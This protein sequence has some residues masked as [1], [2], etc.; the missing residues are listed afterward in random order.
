MVL[1]PT[2]SSCAFEGW[3]EE[4]E[5]NIRTTMEQYISTNAKN[6]NRCV[7]NPIADTAEFLD[8]LTDDRDRSFVE[9]SSE[10]PRIEWKHSTVDY[11]PHKRTP[12]LRISQR[13]NRKKWSRRARRGEARRFVRNPD[14]CLYID[15]LHPAQSAQSAKSPSP[16]ISQDGQPKR[17]PAMTLVTPAH[18]I[19]HNGLLY[20]C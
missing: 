9:M 14:N 12:S 17:I 3:R 16:L 5:Q 13:T 10:L 2:V 1:L 20:R 7:P 11:L 19:S 8:R 18:R 4:R 6:G 15:R